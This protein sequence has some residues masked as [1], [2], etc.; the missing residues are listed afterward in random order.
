MRFSQ[1]ASARVA[2]AGTSA[3]LEDVRVELVGRRAPVV[4]ALR[5]M[6]SLPEDQRRERGAALNQ[7]R[8]ALGAGDRA[9]RG[10]APR[11]GAG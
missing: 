4:L 7:A 6:G 9:A 8:K 5:E 1:T 11:R 10:R 2:A 3:E